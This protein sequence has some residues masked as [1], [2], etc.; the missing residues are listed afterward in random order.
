M[1]FKEIV[2]L[3]SITKTEN[4]MGDVLDVKTTRQVFANK[5]SVRASEFYQA[6]STGLR[7]ELMFEIRSVEY[8]EEPKLIY[9]GKEYNIIR[10]YDKNGEITEL[11]VQ[12]AVNNAPT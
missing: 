4:S 2:E 7:P 10:V 3:V 12:G 5:K 9:N 8:Q 1:L 11:I 6:M